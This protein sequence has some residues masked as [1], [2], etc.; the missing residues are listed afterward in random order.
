MTF[1]KHIFG[2]VWDG[3]R[4]S[5]HAWFFKRAPEGDEMN[6]RVSLREERVV[7]HTSPP[8]MPTRSGMVYNLA[9]PLMNNSRF[10]GNG[11]YA[12]H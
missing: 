2:M 7:F 4:G 10:C 8:E 1:F 12:N 5:R 11:W 3:L 6:R 9:N